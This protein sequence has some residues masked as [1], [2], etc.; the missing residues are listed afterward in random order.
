MRKVLYLQWDCFGEEYICES[1]K[2]AGL[3]VEMYSV[4]Y[5]KVSMRHDEAFENKLE[6]H[7]AGGEYEFVFSFNY[8]PDSSACLP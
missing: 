6:D 4:P 7:L 2:K 3:T 1:L 8:F 5:G